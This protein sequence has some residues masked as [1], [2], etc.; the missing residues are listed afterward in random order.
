MGN[1]GI[2]TSDGKLQVTER[3]EMT[4]I[5]GKWWDFDGTLSGNDRSDALPSELLTFDVY[6]MIDEEKD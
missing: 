5:D 2:L 6:L 3:W 1:N 4:D